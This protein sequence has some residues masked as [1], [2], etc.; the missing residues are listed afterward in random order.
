LAIILYINVA[1]FHTIS[2]Y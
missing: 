1:V 2:H